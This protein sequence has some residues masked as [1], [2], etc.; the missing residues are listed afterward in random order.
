MRDKINERVKAAVGFGTRLG[1]RSAKSNWFRVLRSFFLPS[2]SFDVFFAKATIVVLCGKGF[3]VMNLQGYIF[4]ILFR[5]L[6]PINF[7]VSNSLGSTALLQKED[8]RHTQLI[9]RC[10][11]ARPIGIFRSTDYEFLLCYGGMVI[12]LLNHPSMN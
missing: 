4:E 10:E 9:K 2:D 8:P 12:L 11:N 1:F 5:H 6:S 3:E 7:V